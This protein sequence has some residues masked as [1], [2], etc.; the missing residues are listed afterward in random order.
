MITIL[1]LDQSTRCS[2]WVVI[3]DGTIQ[4]HGVIK[5]PS[6]RK[7]LDAALYQADAIEE[8]IFLRGI[9]TIALEE[10]HTGG[11]TGANIIYLLGALRGMVIRIAHVHDVRYEVVS[12]Q[13]MCAYL[14]IS[15]F[16]AREAKKRA[17]RQIAAIDLFGDRTRWQEIPED[18][19]DAIAIAG[20]AY[21][22]LHLEARIA[23]SAS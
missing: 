10:L 5:T 11:K 21:S 17:S 23:E 7:G 14:G 9:E 2:G 8:M 6:K 1:G 12:T 15:A 16:T 18:T 20:I 4:E 13:D 22:R 19:A 3:T